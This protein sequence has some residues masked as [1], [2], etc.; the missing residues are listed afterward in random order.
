[1]TH[2]LATRAIAA[3][4]IALAVAGCAGGADEPDFEELRAQATSRV[5]VAQYGFESL[6]GAAGSD[7]TLEW[8]NDPPNVRINVESD[9]SSSYWM[10]LPEAST[11]CSDFLPVCQFKP[12]RY[13][14]AGVL[15]DYLDL[16]QGSEVTRQYED[17]V[18]GVQS[19]CFDVRGS[20]SHPL[21][22]TATFCFDSAGVLTRLRASK[23]GLSDVKIEATA[24]REDVDP[25]V[26]LDLTPPKQLKPLTDEELELRRGLK[27]GALTLAHFPDGWFLPI[28][29]AGDTVEP[30]CRNGY[31]DAISPAR[32]RSQFITP[33]YS[34]QETIIPFP[35]GGAEGYIE[36]WRSSL[37][38]CT[39]QLASQ[40]T[41]LGAAAL[42]FPR[43]GDDSLA[44]GV[45]NASN[46]LESAY[47]VIRAG[48]HVIVLEHRAQSPMRLDRDLA[49]E[50]ARIA[51]ANLQSTGVAR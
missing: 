24:V 29:L 25:S 36:L 34:V 15:Q 51:V 4:A 1:M 12:S 23:S 48:E 30:F 35:N 49:E 42:Q 39:A 21:F 8:H 19:D 9:D 2:R 3:A 43:V 17:A 16:A 7:G 6:D 44:I 18:S 50:L 28:V 11:I 27:A 41:E 5:F 47:I 37:E 13:Y 38:R 32:L 26:F 45:N 33:G 14:G 40:G 22:D 46:G 10:D 31:N 20:S